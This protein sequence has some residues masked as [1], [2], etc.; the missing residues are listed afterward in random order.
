MLAVGLTEHHA[1][2]EEQKKFPGSFLCSQVS[3]CRKGLLADFFLSHSASAAHAGIASKPPC[4]SS[5][6]PTDE[7][8]VSKPLPPLR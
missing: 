2:E 6:T 8:D 3:S 1:E 5:L 7:Y 4:S